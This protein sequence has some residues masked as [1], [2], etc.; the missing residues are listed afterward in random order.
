MSDA[1]RCKTGPFAPPLLSSELKI[2]GD[3]ADWLWYGCLAR[4]GI[5][6]LSAL[7]KAGKTTMVAHLLR[8]FE[9]GTPFCGLSTTPAK[10][11]YVTEESERRWAERCNQIGLGD[12]CRWQIR[13]FKARPYAADWKKFLQHPPSNGGGYANGSDCLRHPGR[14]VARQGR[15]RRR[16]SAGM[17][18]A[19]SRAGRD[20]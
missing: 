4:G 8:S 14:P 10:I 6:L 3:G 20:G 2:D 13:P 12:W 17:L 15:E 1:M 5:T 19:T 18:A 7:W 11:L 16:P 9:R